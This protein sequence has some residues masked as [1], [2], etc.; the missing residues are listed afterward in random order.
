MI[1]LYSFLSTKL[2]NTAQII[3]FI[4]IA[5]WGVLFIS[6][7]WGLLRK[8]DHL[9]VHI[10]ISIIA[11][12]FGIKYYPMELHSHGNKNV[13]GFLFSPIVFVLSYTLLRMTY[14]RIY[15]FEPD[16]AAYSNYS[17]RD[18]RGLNFLDY[19]TSITPIAL[20]AIIGMY[21]SNLI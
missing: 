4:G 10:L 6:V 17:N 12:Y 7:F 19:I 3:E 8:D 20:S 2:I 9:I 16:I 14:K 21:L 18:H 11:L 5:Y 15:N 1:Y 13:T